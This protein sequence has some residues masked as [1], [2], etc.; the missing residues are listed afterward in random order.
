VLLGP[1]KRVGGPDGPMVAPLLSEYLR[2]G[3]YIISKTAAA[4]LLAT[5]SKLTLPIDHLLFNPNN[6]PIFGWLKP[7]LLL[8]ALIEQTELDSDIHGLRQRERPRGWLRVAREIVRGYYKMRGLPARIMAL[9]LGRARYVRI[10]LS[11]SGQI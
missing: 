9:A 6:S 2:T 10:S 3:G 5:E 11:E 1:A 8:P 4:A 7:E